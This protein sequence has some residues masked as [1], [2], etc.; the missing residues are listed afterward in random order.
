MRVHLR[1]DFGFIPRVKKSRPWPMVS[2]YLP[3]SSIRQ[4]CGNRHPQL[5][6]LSRFRKGSMTRRRGPARPPF[7]TMHAWPHPLNAAPDPVSV[8]TETGRQ[9]GPRLSCADGE[10]Y[11][12]SEVGQL[13][14]L[15]LGCCS[16]PF[17]SR[18]RKQPSASAEQARKCRDAS[19][20]RWS[21]GTVRPGARIDDTPDQLNFVLLGLQVVFV[22]RFELRGGSGRSRSFAQPSV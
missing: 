13:S 22:Y 5:S 12:R 8:Q 3:A 15:A 21:P 17:A 20:G 9:R 19:A 2:T 18:S 16:K 11:Q 6:G 10:R 14:E 7:P 4:C 1:V